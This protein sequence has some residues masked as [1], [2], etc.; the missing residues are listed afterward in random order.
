MWGKKEGKKKGKYTS[1]S[2]SKDRN[3]D[4]TSEECLLLVIFSTTRLGCPNI[5]DP[6]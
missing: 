2:Q 6:G 5:Q 1:I 4:A 3:K